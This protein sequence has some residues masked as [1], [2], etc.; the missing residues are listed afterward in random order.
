M[1]VT[2]NG[3]K[4]TYSYPKMNYSG[5]KVTYSYP[6]VN[7]LNEVNF[8]VHLF[9]VQIFC[10]IQ[11]MFSLKNYK[12]LMNPFLIDEIIVGKN[13]LSGGTFCPSKQIKILH[14]AF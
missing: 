13:N 7:L 11:I 2:Y 8:F 10:M 5:L 9:I 14:F 6:K 4:V 12:F 1:K 3:L